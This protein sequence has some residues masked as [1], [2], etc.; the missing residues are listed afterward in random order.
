MRAV[1]ARGQHPGFRAI[2]VAP[3]SPGD[4][5]RGAP[6]RFELALGDITA[7]VV[8]AIVTPANQSLLGNSGGVDAA[9]HRASGTELL[10]ACLALGGCAIGDAK[11]TPAFQLSARWIIHAVGPEWQ[12]GRAGEAK[13]LTSA[14]KRSLTVADE[15]GAATVAFPPIANDAHSEWCF[16]QQEAAEIAIDTILSTPTHVGVVRFVCDDRKTLEI[17]DQLLG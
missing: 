7:E 11:V 3:T 10:A 16:P 1:G 4:R 2:A 14:Y 13:L 12:G 8:D 6:P 17:Y 9:I 5:H 15:V